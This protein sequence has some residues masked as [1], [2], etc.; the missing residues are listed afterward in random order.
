[1]SHADR[2]RL[3]SRQQLRAARA[4]G[5]RVG[6]GNGRRREAESGPAMMDARKRLMAVPCG[7]PVM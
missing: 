5:S 6:G 3:S 4:P 7:A 2:G 1:V